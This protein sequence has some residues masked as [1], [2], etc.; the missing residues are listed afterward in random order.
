MSEVNKNSM[1]YWWPLVKDCGVPM[2]R[3]IMVRHEDALKGKLSYA[4]LDGKP[5][6]AFDKMVEGA[7]KAA[8]EIGYP[9]FMRS[10][11][12]ANKHDWE[13]SCYVASEDQMGSHIC[14]ILEMTAMTMFGL[15]FNGVAIR[16]FLDLDWKFKAMYGKMPI[17]REFRMFVRDGVLECWHPYWPPASIDNPTIPNWYDVLKELQ[18][19]S[20]AELKHITRLAETVGRVVGDYWSIDLCQTKNGS[21]YMTDMAIGEDS[22]HWGTCPNASEMM[23]MNYGDP[24]PLQT[25]LSKETKQ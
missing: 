3:T 9:V 21:W 1:F 4:P 2:P 5:D 16:E 17:A 8:T 10:D 12:T 24:D 25:S 15:S 14:N 20:E 7:K 18:T 23:L 13:N 22:Y 6:P 11:G 19:P